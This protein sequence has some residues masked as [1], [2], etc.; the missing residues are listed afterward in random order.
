MKQRIAWTL[1]FVKINKSNES[2]EDNKNN[3][4]RKIITST[5]HTIDETQTITNDQGLLSPTKQP[6]TDH[7]MNETNKSF[8]PFSPSYQLSIYS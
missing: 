6:T 2:N 8:V 4:K 3:S 1:G 5:T 7:T